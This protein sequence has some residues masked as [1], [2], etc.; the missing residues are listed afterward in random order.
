MTVPQNLPPSS[1]RPNRVREHI[2]E[3]K[4]QLAEEPNPGAAGAIDWKYRLCP[5]L[6]VCADPNHARIDRA[7]RDRTIAEIVGNG[8]LELRLNE[9]ESDD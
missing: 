4:M 8:R 1:G 9:S 2:I 6:K 3:I 7:C 5:D